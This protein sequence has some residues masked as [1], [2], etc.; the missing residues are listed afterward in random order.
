M[1]LIDIIALAK[2]GYKKADI[3]ELLKIQVDE[4]DIPAAPDSTDP[5]SVPEGG[6]GE[7]PEKTADD[8]DYK[9][10]YMDIQSEL[11][12]MKNDLKIAQDQNRHVNNS[13]AGNEPDPWK[14]LEEIARGYM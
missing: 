13:G 8:P 4:P 14:D 9:Q 2:A 12:Q 1:N 7:S 10:L 11:E 5:E 6:T 3:D